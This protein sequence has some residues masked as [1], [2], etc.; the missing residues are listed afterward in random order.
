MELTRSLATAA[1]AA[2]LV[3]HAPARAADSRFEVVNLVSDGSVQAAHTDPNLVN[4][5]GVAFNPNGFVWVSGNGSGKSTLYDGNGVPQSLVVQIPSAS[6]GAGKPTGIVFS[7]SSDFAVTNGTATGPSRFVFATEDGLIAGW[8]PNVD[9]T[10]A[11]V[12]VRM[13]GAVYKGL[14]LLGNGTGNQLYAADFVGGRIDVF[15]RAFRPVAPPGGFADP[16][17]PSDFHPFNVQALQGNLYVA[18]AKRAPGATDETAG[19]GQGYVNVFDADGFLIRRIASRGRLDAPWG[20]ALAPLSFGA[21]GNDLLVGN[22]GDGTINAYDPRTG[23]YHGQLRDADGRTIRI[24]GLWG[25]AF[26]NGI[27]GQPADALFFAAGPGDEAH[28]LYGVINA[29]P[30]RADEDED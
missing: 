13:P 22:F 25:L 2:T 27:Q 28:G 1:L 21:F 17:M 15:D 16:R 10:H 24:D 23:A 7:G 19:P 6:S 5:W 11:L 30:S 8:A 20:M 9:G 3:A 14:A 18:Y 26:G 4:G 29:L 12:A